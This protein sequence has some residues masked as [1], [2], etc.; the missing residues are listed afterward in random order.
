MGSDTHLYHLF[1][2]FVKA[3]LAPSGKDKKALLEWKNPNEVCFPCSF[4]LQTLSKIL[5]GLQL[6]QSQDHRSE[7][8]LYIHTWAH[9]HTL[10]VSMSDG[11]GLV[12]KSCPTFVTPW[13]VAWQAPLSVGFPRQ[14]YQ[15]GLPFSSLGDLLHL[16]IKLASPA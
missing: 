7:L 4:L 2:F 3:T 15:N 8:P 1:H 16:E 13:T 9:T 6:A 5:L 12:T 10:S 14:E 11:G